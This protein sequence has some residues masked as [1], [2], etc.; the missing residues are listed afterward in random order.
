MDLGVGEDDPRPRGVLD[1]V[2]RLAVL[3]GD[4]ADG[5]GEMVALQGLDVLDLEGCF[6]LGGVWLVRHGPISHISGAR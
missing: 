1:G 3:A 6:F 5:S 2:L 4:A